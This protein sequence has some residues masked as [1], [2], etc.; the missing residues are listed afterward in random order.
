VRFFGH[1]QFASK[2]FVHLLVGLIGRAGRCR[3]LGWRIGRA[4]WPLVLV[5]LSPA[6]RPR[7]S[8]AVAAAVT[9]LVATFAAPGRRLAA[10]R[11]AV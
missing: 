6:R 5:L 8:L 2:L 9:A 7:F 3:P 4:T 1:V 11:I 10:G